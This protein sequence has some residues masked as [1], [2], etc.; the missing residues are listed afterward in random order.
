MSHPIRRKRKALLILTGALL[1][2]AVVALLLL[3]TIKK[4]FPSE[5]SVIT[6]AENPVRTLQVME[7]STVQQ[8]TV[9]PYQGEG[10]TVERGEAG[11]MLR[12]GDT[13]SPISETYEKMLLSAVTEITIQETVAE[14]AAEVEMYLADMGLDPALS[15]AEVLYTDGRVE[16]LEVG[17]AAQDTTY[18]YF[19]WSGAPGVYMCDEGISD[20]LHL[21]KSRLHPIEQPDLVAPLIDEISITRGEE[22]LTI[23][24]YRDGAGEIAGR[25]E[26]PV[27]YPMDS[28]TAQSLAT[29]CAALRLGTREADRSPENDAA[30]GLTEP[31]CEITIRSRAGNATAIDEEG[32]LT[33][34]QKEA[35]SLRL[36]VGA[37]QGDYFYACGTEEAIYHLNR[38]LLDPFLSLTADSL[39][40]QTPLK[41]SEEPSLLSVEIETA[42]G[43][44]HLE[45]IWAEN[46]DSESLCLVN[47]QEMPIERYETL[48]EALNGFTVGGNLPTGYVPEG[49]ASPRWQVVLEE[50]DGRT[51]KVQGW[52]L[53]LFS[54]AISVDG[55]FVHYGDGETVDGIL[56]MPTGETT[57]EE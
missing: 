54:D 34:V 7:E 56:S 55:V 35:A 16:T 23:R 8:I 31:L 27:R 51:R 45:P 25:L 9:T 2:L 47:D 52:R 12:E 33:V 44:V 19:R 57:K 1:V 18:S 48:L 42:E 26:A 37:A 21:T 22:T 49:N 40:T 13:L 10:F 50:T 30:Y 32:V 5:K 53:D 24:L 39:Y 41:L 15:R 4:A 6:V 20:A 36:L 17:A 38:I 14:D 43:I 28:E 11:L 46:A 29:A 3:P